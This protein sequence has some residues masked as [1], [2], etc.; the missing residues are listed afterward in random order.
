MET[1]NEKTITEIES[2]VQQFYELTKN[3]P[4]E[5]SNKLKQFNSIELE[6]ILEENDNL[7]IDLKTL[8]EL[9]K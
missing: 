9:E 4:I 2:F 8:L 1:F 7:D 6:N 3:A 5:H